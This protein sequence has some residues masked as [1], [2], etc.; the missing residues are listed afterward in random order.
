MKV[1]IHEK[2]GHGASVTQTRTGTSNALQGL[3]KRN[4]TKHNYDKV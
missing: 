4:G 1:Y 2:H 3:Q